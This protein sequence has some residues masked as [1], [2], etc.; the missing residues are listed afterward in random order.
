MIK[1]VFVNIVLQFL[2]SKPVQCK[3]LLFIGYCVV[4]F[5]VFL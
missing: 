5:N 3:C 4:D 1:N 2:L